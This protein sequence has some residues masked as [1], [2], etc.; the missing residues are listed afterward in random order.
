MTSILPLQAGLAVGDLILAVNKDTLLGSTYDAVSTDNDLRKR[1]TRVLTVWKW[2]GNPKCHFVSEQIAFATLN[3][4]RFDYIL[5]FVVAEENRGRRHVGGV[6]PAK[7]WRQHVD[8][9]KERR[10]Q[11]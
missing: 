3:A 6:Q 5:G 2:I 9:P 8:G 1:D 11:T 10:R 4:R 7:R